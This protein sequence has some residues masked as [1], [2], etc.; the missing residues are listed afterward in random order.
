MI[1]IDKL[2]TGKPVQFRHVS[3]LL[4][5]LGYEHDR[6]NGTHYVFVK[7]GSK[8]HILVPFKTELHK[9]DVC[10]VVRALKANGDLEE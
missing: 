7:P 1:T 8:M 2:K 4:N 10:R 3:A 5:C 6:A 9:A